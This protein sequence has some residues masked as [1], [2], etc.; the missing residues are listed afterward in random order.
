MVMESNKAYIMDTNYHTFEIYYTNRR[1]M[2]VIDDEPIHTIT[3]TTSSLTDTRHFRAF[4]DSKNTGVGTAVVSKSMV[5]TINRYGSPTSQPK[6]YFKQGVTAGVLLKSGVGSLHSII[7]SGVANNSVITIYDG[8]STAGTILW[9]SGAMTNQTV[10]F[11]L[12]FN[13]SGPSQFENGLFLVV[14]G[15]ASNVFVKYE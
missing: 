2:F 11:D 13:G 7:I 12:S 14:S 10:P 6:T 4:I 15:A 3:A 9:T 8:L 5:L 1:V